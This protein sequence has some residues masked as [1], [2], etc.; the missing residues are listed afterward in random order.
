MARRCEIC[1]K[2]VIFGNRVS[3]SNMKTTRKFKPNLHKVTAVV[4]GSKK[5][6]KVCTK[7]LRKLQRV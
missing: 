4:N 7:C 1:G 2:G 5:R 3:H 6:V